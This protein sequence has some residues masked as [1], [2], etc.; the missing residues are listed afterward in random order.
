[1]ALVFFNDKGRCRTGAPRTWSTPYWD[2]PPARWRPR[3]TIC[4]FKRHRPPP[5]TLFGLRTGARHDQGGRA[6]KRLGAATRRL[7]RAVWGPR[8]RSL[9]PGRTGAANIAAEH[10]RSKRSRPIT[11]GEGNGQRLRDWMTGERGRDAAH[12]AWAGLKAPGGPAKEDYLR[13]GHMGHVNAHMVLGLLA[14]LQPGMAAM[15]IPH[16]PTGLERRST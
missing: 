3:N 2:W 10:K 4:F 8:S 14:N 7:A 6:G 11:F 13:I 1:M 9:G 5:T 15:Q 16:G 12:S